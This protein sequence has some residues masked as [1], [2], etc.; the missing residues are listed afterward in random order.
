[1]STPPRARLDL[2]LISVL[3]LF[4]ELA[5]I[6]W[7]PSHVLFLTFFTNTVLLAAVLGMS[8]GC[9]AASRDAQLSA[10]DAAPARPRARRRAPGRVRAPALE[11]FR[12]C[13]QP[14][15]AAAG[16]L[17]RGVPAARSVD[18]RH[19]D[20]GAVRHLLRVH[21]VVDGGAGPAVGP[22]AREAVESGRVLHRQHPRQHRR[23][24]AVRRVLVVRGAAGRLV[25]D[26]RC[27]A[28]AIS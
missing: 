10:V 17:R 22:L 15:V 21:R 26:R 19:P 8:V 1:M 4:L 7:F 16:V 12:R 27:W 24:R 5:S 14:G 2:F 3:V 28:S 9:L 18:V 25:R 13:R 11:Q 6:R 23:H 20:R